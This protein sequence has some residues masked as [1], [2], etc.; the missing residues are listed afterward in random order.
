M[1]ASPKASHSVEVPED[2]FFINQFFGDDDMTNRNL[3]GRIIVFFIVLIS[4]F[5]Y[6]FL[7]HRLPLPPL[8]PVPTAPEPHPTAKSEPLLRLLLLPLD[9]RP[10]CSD[11]VL[12]DSRLASVEIL[13]PPQELMASYTSP[14]NFREMRQSLLSLAR[15]R[16]PD[17]IILSI[18]QLLAGGLLASLDKLITD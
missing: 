12:R 5:A 16:Q 17:G 15:E 14:G 2:S 11:Y 10:P 3:A 1:A 18:D 8:A 7:T 13:L 4:A 9:S 6:P